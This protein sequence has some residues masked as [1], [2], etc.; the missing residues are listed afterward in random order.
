MVSQE[1]VLPLVSVELVGL[2]F[3]DAKPERHLI[4]Y[5]S[6]TQLFELIKWKPHKH[7]GTTIRDLLHVL[8]NMEAPAN[9]VWAD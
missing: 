3:V 2:K 7:K 1:N 6:G 8:Q 9:T 4:H 5:S